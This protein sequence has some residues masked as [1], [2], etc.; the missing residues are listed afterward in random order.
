MYSS[1]RLHDKV[2][3]R[4][5]FGHSRLGFHWEKEGICSQCDDQSFETDDHV[6]FE[7]PAYA[8]DRRDLES[9]MFKLGYKQVTDET[10]LNP[11][12]EHLHEVVKA[13]IDFLKGTGCLDRI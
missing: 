9:V 2:N 12:R 7:C 8:D 13:V 11:P 1:G 5:R 3:T 10:L 6:F 4:L